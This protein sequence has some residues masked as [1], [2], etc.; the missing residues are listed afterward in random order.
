MVLNTTFRKGGAKQILNTTF[1]KGGA[2]RILNTT[3]RKGGAKQ[4]L[5]A[6]RLKTCYFHWYPKSIDSNKNCL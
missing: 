1:R 5:N 3:F 2:K 6:D 4:I